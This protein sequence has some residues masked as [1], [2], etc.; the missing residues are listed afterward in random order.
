MTGTNRSS[1]VAEGM[2]KTRGESNY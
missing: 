1:E 2:G